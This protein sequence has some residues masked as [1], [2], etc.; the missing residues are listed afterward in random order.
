LELDVGKG[1]RARVVWGFGNEKKKEK[2]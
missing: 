2:E 1:K